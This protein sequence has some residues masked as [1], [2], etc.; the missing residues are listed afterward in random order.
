M[1]LTGS[2]VI[3]AAVTLVIDRVRSLRSG[4]LAAWIVPLTPRRNRATVLSTLEQTD[5][6]SQVTIGPGLGRDRPGR[7]HPGGADG[8]RRPAR[9]VGN[10]RAS[11]RPAPPNVLRCTRRRACARCVLT[12]RPSSPRPTGR[13]RRTTSSS[14]SASR[15][16]RRG[17]STSGDSPISDA[18]ST[19]RRGSCRRRSSSPTSTASIVGRTSIR[20]ELNDFLPRSGGHIGYGVLADA[21]SSRLRHGD[22]PP[23]PRH[24]PRRRRR[25][26]ARDV[27]RRQR[28][29]G[30]RDRA[31]R[32]C[33]TSRR[34][35]TGDGTPP[36]AATGSTDGG[37]PRRAIVRVRPAAGRAIASTR[38]AGASIR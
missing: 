2:F 23:E 28:R 13:W 24:R 1:A 20:H 37:V 3:A 10:R 36:C 31:L 29:L 9:A 12:T 8:Q 34:S 35:T 38:S 27:R 14:A 21:P 30:D 26:R 33:A 22:P 32:R 6:I 16:V 7:R 25:A 15:R 19:S 17:R 5:S 18:A 4:L 11:R